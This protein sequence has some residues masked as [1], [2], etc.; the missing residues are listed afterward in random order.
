MLFSRMITVVISEIH[1]RDQNSK[2]NLKIL[3]IYADPVIKT[4][5]TNQKFQTFPLL[6]N[7]FIYSLIIF[8]LISTKFEYFPCS[9]DWMK[10]REKMVL[11]L[12]VFKIYLE[13]HLG[14]SV[15]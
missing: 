6:I 11:A 5:K 7:V 9:S 14:G 15:G 2:N 4:L 12:K 3:V 8:M 10:Y 1:K 13:G